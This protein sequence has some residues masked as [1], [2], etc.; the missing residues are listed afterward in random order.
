MPIGRTIG[1]IKR[2]AGGL[3]DFMTGNRYDFDKRGGNESNG[4]DDDKPKFQ[5]YLRQGFGEGLRSSADYFDGGNK[6]D[7]KAGEIF[8]IGVQTPGFA[9]LT[10]TMSLFDP[11]AKYPTY[12]FQGTPGTPGFLQSAAAGFARGFGASLLA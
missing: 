4:D 7:R 2:F 10:E 9:Q 12:G 5:D 3:A 8:G 11:A 6:S 1:G